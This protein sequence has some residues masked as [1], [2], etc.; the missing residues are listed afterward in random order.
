MRAIF[1][2][3]LIAL[4]CSCS[5]DSFVEQ[6]YSAIEG[7]QGKQ[8]DLEELTDFQWDKL[9]L[10]GPYSQ[11]DSLVP[12]LR[13]RLR[14]RIKSNDGICLLVFENS[15]AI[16][17]VKVLKRD[18]GDF[19]YRNNFYT[20][21]NNNAK[22]LVEKDAN[23]WVYLSR[24]TKNTIPCIYTTN[25]S[26]PYVAEL[27]PRGK[28]A[29]IEEGNLKICDT[30]L[31]RLN[32][33]QQGL[34]EVLTEL[35]GWVF[36]RRNGETIQTVT[37]DNGP[38]ILNEGLI[39]YVDEKKIGFINKSGEIKIE[40]KYTFAYPFQDNFAL[41]CNECRKESVGEHSVMVNGTWGYIDKN[42][43]EVIPVKFSQ[44]NAL[45]KMKDMLRK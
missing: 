29:Y 15:G 39:R 16:I 41:V 40:A 43:N 11:I 28:C 13:K 19:A 36:V 45:L 22:F 34:A 2:I 8:I 6:L 42:G 31:S 21:T 37:Y 3:I 5:K 12:Q 7:N 23:G 24:L 10:A 32:F 1:V 35:Y 30:S 18:R 17:Y 26:D 27:Q 44:K 33:S 4:I 14:D 38:D 20:L 25:D 9:I